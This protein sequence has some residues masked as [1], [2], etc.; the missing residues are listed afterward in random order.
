[1]RAALV[2]FVAPL[3]VANASAQATAAAALRQRLA[4]QPA[5]TAAW[6]EAGFE[7]V[8]A[9]F[10]FD[11]AAAVKSASELVV[12]ARS[13][14]RSDLEIV[15]TALHR[16]A[17]GIHEGPARAGNAP[18]SGDPSAHGEALAGERWPAPLRARLHAVRA[19]SAWLVDAPTEFL[20]DAF[21]ALVTARAAEAAVLQVRAAWTLH[22]VLENEAESYD[23]ELLREIQS[24]LGA[25]DAAVFV[26]WYDLN[27]YWRS[28]AQHTR[29]ER[30]LAL[31]GILKSADAIGDL[32]TRIHAE[33]DRAGI[34]MSVD[35]EAAEHALQ[36]ARAACD[37]LGDRRLTAVALEQ[38]AELAIERDRPDA[39][40]DWLRR[41]GEV[42]AERGFADREVSQAH[43]RLQLA[44][45]RGDAAAGSAETT[46]L[47]RLRREEQDRYRGYSTLRERLLSGE[48]QRLE[49]EK[50]LLLERERAAQAVA[51]IRN[52]AL[53]GVIVAL[54]AIATTALI[55]RRRL[56]R[57][58]EEL[59][60]Q[61]ERTE[62][63]TDL[64][65]ALEQR[66]Q[67]LERADSLGVFASGIAHD[68]NNLMVGV[69]GN[70]ELLRLGEL[71]PER[72]RLLAALSAAG[73]RGA[74][75]CRQLQAHASERPSPPAPFD[76]A[77][78]VR[79][80]H[81]VLES[82]AS[83][84]I[85]VELAVEVEPLQLVGS[86]TEVEQ[87]VLNL[88]AN[89]RDAGATRAR[90]CIGRDTMGDADWPRA[91]V[92]GEPRAGSFAWLDV[93][94]NGEGMRDDQV[95]RIF[96]PFFTT[97]FPGRGLGLACV[98]AV[99]RHHRGVVTVRSRPGQGSSFRVY[100]PLSVE[101]AEPAL[102]AAPVAE[103]A[104]ESAA[105]PH[106]GSSGAPLTVL[107]VDDEV[108]VREY[109]D[110]ALRRRGHR[111][112]CLDDGAEI[113][114]A[115]AK[116]GNGERTVALVDL[117]MPAMDGR[118]VVQR[119]RQSMPTTAIV[120]MSGHSEDHLAEIARQ[121]DADGFVAKPFSSDVLV[122]TL[123]DA[124]QR[125]AARRRPALG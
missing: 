1:M 63:E 74:R 113:P 104:A 118:D 111:V 91:H 55:G 16:L 73:E 52:I 7:V 19:R 30:L 40:A 64:R 109:L 24:L 34:E 99:L 105:V 95:D 56:R 18:S 114:L 122:R 29:E 9:E 108:R 125:R 120:L 28:S 112:V 59:Q 23:A 123:A 51:T 22:L 2:L 82:S 85:A 78:L 87:V 46:L 70:A 42:V 57:A 33:W 88:V 106:D 67:R 66:M 54:G 10:A 20:A 103:S 96:D 11:V 72:Q 121:L 25:P 41:A 62:A 84:R 21:S 115:A 76:L 12:A 83:T 14:A 101:G 92:F 107:V 80:L 3:F 79:S 26:P 116:I 93:E 39:A 102:A 53:V 44:M 94:D 38:L 31:A 61:V 81:P 75:L 48:R 69:V 13:A 71:D 89:A 32:R 6:F 119:V 65:R 36:S 90:I 100:L 68:F 50:G 8:E 37:H 77:E 97:R 98:L 124:V 45:R 4:T 17:V 86:A 60:Q 43:L 15:A 117:T 49:F 110:L 58:H 35:V 27:V 5:G 47:G